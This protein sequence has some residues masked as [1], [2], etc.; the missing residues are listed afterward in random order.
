[1]RI[2]EKATKSPPPP[3]DCFGQA[4]ACKAAPSLPTPC[5]AS[6]KPPALSPG[7]SAEHPLAPLSDKMALN[8]SQFLQDPSCK[9]GGETC[10]SDLSPS[11]YDRRWHTIEAQIPAFD[12]TSGG[13][14]FL[15]LLSPQSLFSRSPSRT[16]APHAHPP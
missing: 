12:L 7:S 15:P 9:G 4:W 5:T 10:T 13:G 14:A 3:S 2:A 16:L 8:K 11:R 6:R 1:V